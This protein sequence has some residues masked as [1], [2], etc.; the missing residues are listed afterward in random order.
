MHVTV[1]ASSFV[2]VTLGFVQPS[3][4]IFENE[5]Y[6]EVCI[7]I[8][9]VPDDGLECDVEATIVV[10]PSVKTSKLYNYNNCPDACQQMHWCIDNLLSCIHSAIGVDFNFF[11]SAEVRFPSSTTLSGDVQCVN[12]TIED[13][14][15]VEG[16]HTIALQLAQGL[17]S[18]LGQI[19][20]N[21]VSS[22][23]VI[24]DN[25]GKTNVY[26][27]SDTKLNSFHAI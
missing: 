27:C 5:S 9:S 3:Y 2:G 18:P 12:I 15:I 16:D 14:R 19:D 23:I 1:H 4:D 6:V 11:G 25:D 24:E 10:P 7:G 8:S 20:F 26:A 22:V 17:E 21:P 13:D